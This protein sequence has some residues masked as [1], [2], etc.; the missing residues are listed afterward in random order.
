MKQFHGIMTALVTPLTKD[1]TVDEAKMSKLV[2]FQIENGVSSLLVLGGTG[3]YSALTVE[4][5]T[6]AVEATVRAA[7][8]RVPVVAGVLDPG[9][10]EAI[11]CGKSFKAAGADAL[12]VLTPFYVHPNQDGIIDF[13][14][15]FDQ[16]LNCPFLIYNIPY[17]TYV[18]ILPETVEKLVDELPNLVGMKECSPS[19]GQALELIHRVG[20][21]ISVLSGEEFLCGGEML[22]GAD[23]AVMATAN[24]VPD[25]WVK[26]YQ[27]AERQDIPQMRALLKTYFPLFKLMFKEINPGPLKYAM[28][29]IGIDAGELSIPLR[30]PSAALQAEID[31]ELKKLGIL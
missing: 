31:A 18:N 27:A 23:G 15:K 3:E 26:V 28:G 17:R 6:H 9:I 4:E 30:A 8:G 29:K 22:L 16:E 20:D 5:R 7:A 24:L 14:K 1:N 13:Y 2:N 10:G 25:V 19:F 11:K 12:L 21:R